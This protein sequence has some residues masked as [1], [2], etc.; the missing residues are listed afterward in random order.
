LRAQG[1]SIVLTGDFNTAHNEIDLARPKG[2]QK[3]SGFMP[4]EREALG[5]YFDNG[6]VDT[7][8]QLNPDKVQYTWWSQRA[9][10]A[11]ANNIGWRLD[12]FLV[13]DDLFPNVKG[14]T[15]FD[16]VT[17]SDHCPVMLEIKP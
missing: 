8:R 16:D 1:K 14:V 6:L 13:S 3:T 7:F 4:I 10:S 11:R 12:Y 15:I 9:P 5:K 2:N 17:G